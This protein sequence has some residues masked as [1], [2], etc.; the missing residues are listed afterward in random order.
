MWFPGVLILFLSTSAAI[1]MSLEPNSHSHHPRTTRTTYSTILYY[2]YAV[3]K[4]Y[5]NIWKRL[6][7]V[8]VGCATATTDN[9]PNR[10]VAA[11]SGPLKAQTRFIRKRYV[12]LQRIINYFFVQPHTVLWAYYTTRFPRELE[13]IAA[14]LQRCYFVWLIFWYAVLRPEYLIELYVSVFQFFVLL[15]NHFSIFK[16]SDK[17]VTLYNWQEYGGFLPVLSLGCFSQFRKWFWSS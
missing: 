3:T 9:I 4:I 16:V 11:S 14:V 17:R 8:D 2:R 13:S 1:L 10:C 6:C 15:K 12:E 7:R 5:Q